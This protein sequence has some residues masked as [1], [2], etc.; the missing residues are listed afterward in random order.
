MAGRPMTA[1]GSSAGEVFQLIRNGQAKTRADVAKS[2]GMSRTAVTLRVEQLL[3]HGLVVERAYGAATRGR[4][5]AQLEF[6]AAGGVVLAAALGASRAQLAV[7]D[8]A[9]E[10]LAETAL[11]VDLAEG[12]EALLTSAARDLE[13]LR[14]ES[15]H[16]PDDLRGIG[17][18]VPGAVDAGTGRSVSPP[19]QPG[20]GDV[21]IGDFFGRR[22]GVPVRVDNDVNVLALAEA[23][24]HADVDDLLVIKASTGVGAGIVAG[25]RL[26]RGALGAAGEIGHVKVAG[27][28]GETCRCGDVDCLETVA[29]GWA[30]ARQLTEMG[31]P[32]DGA[33]GVARLALDGDADAIRVLRQAGRRIGEVV[34]G[35][36]NLLN[37]AVIVVGGDLAEAFDPL[38]AGIRELVYQRSSAMATRGLRI[39][40]GVLH[41]SAGVANCAVL[42]LGEVL[43]ARA[44]DTL[45]TGRST[46]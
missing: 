34:A 30:L 45:V 33:L 9:G 19:V 44:I 17:V 20:W 42:V 1:P 31:K 22:F 5:A 11:S 38:V 13:R 12:P 21:E 35:A 23:Q 32:V 10:V 7:C 4:P 36:V 8:L 2:T 15:G 41:A 18:S 24:L 43:S 6:N 46:V 27:G 26:Q 37:P 3:D 29:A 14:A 39:E 28:A 40:P 25:G 16:V